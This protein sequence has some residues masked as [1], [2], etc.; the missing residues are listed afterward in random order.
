MKKRVLAVL[1]ALT[2]MAMG[3]VT[4]MAESPSVATTPA[5]VSTQKATVAVEETATPAE[6][7]AATTASEGFAV[8]AVTETVAKSAETAI[9]NSVLTDVAAIGNTLGNTT[10]TAAATDSSKKVTAS[11]VSTVEVD[12][13][14]ATKNASGQYVVTLSIANIAAGDAIVVLHY[15]GTA[16]ECIAPSSVAAGSVTFATASL[17]PISIVKLEVA[18]VK[19]SPKTGDT[20]PMAAAVA[21]LGLA[22]AVVCTKKYFA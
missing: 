11:I 7:A 14:T 13:T 4:V 18:G 21:V 16:W 12:P 15:N 1:T 5:T 17:S 8:E 20:M 2:V 10:L 19:A 3:T 6:Y 9:Q 22:G